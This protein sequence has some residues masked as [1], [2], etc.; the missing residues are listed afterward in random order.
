[1]SV[2][3]VV[4][5]RMGSSRLPGKTLM[6]WSNG[7]WLLLDQVLC[8]VD[9]CGLPVWIATTE[10]VEDDQ[11]A[12][13][14]VEGVYRGPSED[15]LARFVGCIDAM[16]TEPQAI[17]RVCA[18]RPFIVPELVRAMVRYW[19]ATPGPD[20]LAPPQGCEA[21]AGEIV[22]VK[23]LRKLNATPGVSAYEREHV[24]LGLPLLDRVVSEVF[25]VSVDTAD[26]YRK[27]RP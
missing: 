3:A 16:P 17:L 27:L 19:E 26:D 22:S 14:R 10:N 7:G 23:A 6:E 24:T 18:D 25:P 5:A 20:Y 1:M 12:S 13:Y 2:V 8:S 9:A 21:F 15:V 11:I 4:Q